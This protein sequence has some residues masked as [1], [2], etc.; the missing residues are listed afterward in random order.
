MPEEK[1]LPLQGGRK[2]VC[3]PRSSSEDIYEHAKCS[4][5]CKG[6]TIRARNTCRIGSPP[7]SLTDTADTFNVHVL[8]LLILLLDHT[9]E[10]YAN[11]KLT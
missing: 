8:L 1:S 6:Y 7:S 9:S 11:T 5:V 10:S 2:M 4:V 3:K